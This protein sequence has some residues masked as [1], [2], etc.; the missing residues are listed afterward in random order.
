MRFAV[1]IDETVEV[2]LPCPHL[3][4]RVIALR[5]AKDT[6]PFAYLQGMRQG[7]LKAMNSNPEDTETARAY[8]RNERI[9]FAML[10]EAVPGPLD[11]VISPPSRMA[12][13]AEP[14]RRAIMSAHSNVTD[15]TAAV[16]RIGS[17]RAGEGA[18]L[19]DILDSLRYQPKGTEKD[20]RRIVIVDDT[21]TSGTTAAAVVKLLRQ[22]GLSEEC[23]VIFACPMWLDTCKSKPHNGS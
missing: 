23:E 8:H 19:E 18:S 12:W 11:A 14:Y 13:Q 17:A 7:T 5:K 1:A 2:P 3:S 16:S 22:N 10:A 6:G 4:V 9:Y 20:F 21:F 15:L